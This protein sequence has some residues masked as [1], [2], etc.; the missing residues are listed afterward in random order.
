M[1][2]KGIRGGIYYAIHQYQK[3]NNK[4]NKDFDKNKESS[5]LMNWNVNN[6]YGWAIF[7]NFSLAGF[8]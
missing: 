8:K 4:Y 3:A 7:Q 6:S 5:Y 1:V 2:K